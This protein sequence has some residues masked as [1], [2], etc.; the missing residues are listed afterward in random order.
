MKRR[1]FIAGLGAAAWPLT[2]WAQ[3]GE[4]MRRVGFLTYGSEIDPFSFPDKTLR[5]EFEKFG[6]TQGRNLRLDFHFASGDATRTRIFAAD[7]VRLAP[8]VIVAVYGAALRA[9]QQDDS[10]RSRRGR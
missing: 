6:W 8:D 10:D 5:D 1:E 7:L 3:Q 9:L 4:R 2:A